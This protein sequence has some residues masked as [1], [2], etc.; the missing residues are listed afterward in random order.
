VTL[1]EFKQSLKDPSPPSNLSVELEALWWDGKGEWNKAHEVVQDV[2]GSTAAWIHA[3]L[4][5]KEGDAGNA[6][7][8]YS[9][10][11]RPVVTG[12][13]EEE[14]SSIAEYFLKSS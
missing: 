9:R 10:A 2:S 6:Q 11:G 4:H 14:W 12:R 5:R 3:Y 1:A 8:W 7:Y 13:L